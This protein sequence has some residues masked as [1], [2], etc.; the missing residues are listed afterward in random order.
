L[1]L[2]NFSNIIKAF[3]NPKKAFTYL[4]LG[5]QKYD[6]LLSLENH[7]CTTIKNYNSPL[8][9]RMVVPTDIH[10]HLATLYLLTVEL[11]L[12]NIL[13]LGTRT[14]ESTIAFLQA[15][16]EIGG[17]VTSVD[18]DPCPDAKKLVEKN[19]LDE[20]WKFI[21]M[22][23]LDLTWNQPIDHLFIDTAHTYEHTL[24]ELKKFEPMVRQGG[25]IS[26]HDIIG[27]P[28]VLT[29]INEY[30]TDKK[31]I[32]FYKYFHNNGLG[33]LKKI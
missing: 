6:Q 24:K 14:G 27:A 9:S 32:K 16:K 7:S 13:E 28:E 23:D 1:S 10:E 20:K 4:I 3:N 12:K 19:N 2:V 22:D 31:N 30:I 33:I 17:T 5:K 29:A 25:I 26:L 15:A 8:E 18:I 21:Q 11:Q